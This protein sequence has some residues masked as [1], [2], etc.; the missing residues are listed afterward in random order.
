MNELCELLRE[1][2]VVIAALRA[3]SRRMRETVQENKVEKRP[4]MQRLL[5]LRMSES[6]IAAHKTAKIDDDGFTLDLIENAMR[7]VGERLAKEVGDGRSFNRKR[8]KPL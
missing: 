3:T 4:T 7:H 1:Q 5:L 8:I 2:R 6:L